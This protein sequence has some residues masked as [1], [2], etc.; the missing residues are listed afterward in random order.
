M[1]KPRCSKCNDTFM[2]MNY[3][4]KGVHVCQDCLQKGFMDQDKLTI[5]T[6]EEKV[7]SSD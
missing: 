7:K 5:K 6:R 2:V 1:E 4:N 3:N